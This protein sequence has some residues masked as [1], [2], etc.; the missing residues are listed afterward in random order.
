MRKNLSLLATLAI[1]IGLWG[2]TV[3]MQSGY[4]CQHIDD[5]IY[6]EVYS[7][8]TLL[9]G[10]AR[11]RIDVAHHYCPG[12]E[13]PDPPDLPDS[14][15]GF[16]IP[17]CF[18]HTNPSKYC[19]VSWDWNNLL[20]YPFPDSMIER[21]IFRHFIE[22]ESD[23]VVHNWMMDLSQPLMGLEW[24]TRILDLDDSSHF[25]LSLLATGMHDLYFGNAGRT[26]LATITFR[27]EDTMTI[28]VDS[29][30]WPPT[31][32]LVFIREDDLTFFPE[33]NLP[34]CFSLT[35]PILGDMNADGAVNVGDI[36]YLLNYLY[37]GGNPPTPLE[38]GDVNSDGVIN[39]GDVVY[40]INYLYR[41][42]PAP[43][44]PQVGDTNCD[45]GVNVGDVVFLTSY[46]FRGGPPLGC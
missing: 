8:D 43:P 16:V 29:C 36:V 32:R 35:Y 39:V 27:T 24:D 15:A 42:G 45:Q 28:C 5:T 22:P 33:I 2:T 12:G 46:L 20:L 19:S 14:L 13:G 34:Y 11:V 23:T 3:G 6:V 31:Q 26:L 30:F 41:Q 21:S 1:F 7:P 38:V 17:L 37:R 9:S 10:L 25:W 44:A 40:L 18:T 4:P